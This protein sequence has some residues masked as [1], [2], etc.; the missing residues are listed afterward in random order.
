MQRSLILPLILYFV[1]LFAFIFGLDPN[2]GAYKDYLNHIKLF[3]DLNTNFAHTLMNYE[4]YNTRHSPVLYIFIS[5][6]YKFNIPDF[7]VRF[8][9]IHLSL[10]L[11]FFFYKC[12]TIKFKEIEKKYLIFLSSLI[13]LSPSFW[14]LS[15]W[16][17]SRIFGLLFFT[18]SVLFFLKFDLSNN[19]SEFIKCVFAYTMASYLS[20][21]F[22]IFSIY[23]IY[24]FIKKNGFDK[25][26]FLLLFLNII[27]SFPAFY[28]LFSLNEIFL[29]KS[30]VPS[31][32]IEK[33]DFLNIFNKLL[34]IPSI[35][36][37]YLLPL[38]LSN[39]LKLNLINFKS[40]T[41]SIIILMISIYYFNY[42]LAFTGGGIF[43]KVSN[44]LFNTNYLFYFFC[45][46]SI[47]IT[48][49]LCLNLNNF[50][51]ILL[52]LISNPQ[53]TIYHKYF[54][55]LLL[56]LFLTLF[57]LDFKQN[58]LFRNSTIM[59]FYLH[60]LIFLIMNFLK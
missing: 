17:D 27:L 32:L 58:K 24:T 31:T 40:T 16:P 35:L 26:F 46:P 5:F 44:Y 13:L 41:I 29:F 49:I 55:P 2:G 18:I 23:F 53:Y 9:S 3:K 52:L 60:S 1:F 34:I 7:I 51:I 57:N 21:N 30:A 6:F 45:I 43:L 47:F 33:K 37:F 28:Y 42:D 22:A 59:I 15:I 19:F 39:S 14:S 20:P 56:I 54:D 10:L 50:I 4:N 48:I 38:L 25:K 11:P 36:F 12:L 8:T